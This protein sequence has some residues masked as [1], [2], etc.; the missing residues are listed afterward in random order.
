[1]SVLAHHLEIHHLKH[2]TLQTLHIDSTALMNNPLGDPAKRSHPVLVPKGHAPKDGHPVVFM[3]SGFTGN[4][5]NALNIKTFEMNLPQQ[6]DQARDT[7]EAPGAVF[8][9]IDA[10]TFWGG[11][12]F[13]NSDGTGKYEDFIARETFDAVKA[14]LKVSSDPKNW[15]VTGGSSGGYGALHL[16]SKF[17]EKFGLCAAIA[18]DS[19]FEA[20]LLNE[21]RTSLPLLTKFG[22]IDAVKTELASGRLM[23]RKEAHTLLNAI[24]MGLCYAPDGKGR[25]HWPVDEATGLVKDDVWKTW[26]AHDPLHFLSQRL[27]N[28]KKLSGIFLDC[29]SRDQF[30]LQYGSRQIQL[31][32]KASGIGVDYG[33]FDGNH[34]DIGERRP[35]VWKWLAHQWR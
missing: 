27:D 4:G 6:L 1:M 16:A 32:L 15:C 21:I 28:L 18:P 13:V 29:G 17:P 12:Q 30:Q 11:S 23:K 24:A 19:F 25:V 33:E 22:G 31:L 9:L 34:F 8:V 20:S 14:N 26:L 7:G 10:M 5:P 3:L 2:F 35:L